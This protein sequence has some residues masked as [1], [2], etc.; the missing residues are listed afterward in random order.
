MKSIVAKQREHHKFIFYDLVED[1]LA[2]VE[3]TN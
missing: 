3:N 1:V 2:D